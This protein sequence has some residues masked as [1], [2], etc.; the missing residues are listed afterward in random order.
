MPKVYDDSW[1]YIF[2]LSS[3]TC[4]YD[5]LSTQNITIQKELICLNIFVLPIIILV[6]NIINYKYDYKTSIKGIIT[7][8][9]VLFILNVVIDFSLGNIFNYENLSYEMIALFITE[10]INLIIYTFLFKHTNRGY[11]LITINY[12]LDIIFYY[13]ITTLFNLKE[14]TLNTFLKDYFIFIIGNTLS[15]IIISIFD[16]L[17]IKNYESSKK[18]IPKIIKKRT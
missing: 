10:I 9:I 16:K 5:A 12:I 7:S 1:I 6:S 8:L 3:F 17:L 15:I 11:I 13:F 4:L 14:I 18:W 2:L